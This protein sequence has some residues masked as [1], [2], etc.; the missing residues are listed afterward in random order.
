M[1]SVQSV[2]HKVMCDYLSEIINKMWESPK[3]FIHK[4]RVFKSPAEVAL[5]Q[6]SCDIAS[7]AIIRTI[8]ASKPGRHTDCF[9]SSVR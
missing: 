2:V 7:E 4:L 8:T 9:I 5:L 1:T 6:K 3:A